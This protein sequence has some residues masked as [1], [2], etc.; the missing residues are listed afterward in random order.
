MSSLTDLLVH[1]RSFRR[2]TEAPITPDDLHTILEAAL[3][4]PTGKNLRPWHFIT[5]TDRATLGL[6]AEA[7]DAGAAPLAGAAVAI[8]LAADPEESNT[9]LED[10]SIAA[11][12]IQ[13]QCA[14]LGLGSCWIQMRDKHDAAGHDTEANLRHALCIPD[15]MRVPIAIA[16]G[17]PDEARRPRDLAQLTWNRVHK[18]RF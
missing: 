14:A 2:Y 15:R 11:A 8:V 1:R 6:L 16:I 18:D 4:A 10:L 3:L 13:L 5:V 9:W 7:K 12:F 17:H